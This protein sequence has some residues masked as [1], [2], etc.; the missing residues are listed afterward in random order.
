MQLNAKPCCADMRHKQKSLLIKNQEAACIGRRGGIRTRDPL[1][2][3]QVRYQAALHAEAMIVI[4][5]HSSP[6]KPGAKKPRFCADALKSSTYANLS[7]EF[8]P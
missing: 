2:P 3:M 8:A 1:H 5:F 6:G 4:H 7:P